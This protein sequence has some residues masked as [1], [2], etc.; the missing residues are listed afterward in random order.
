MLELLNCTEDIERLEKDQLR[1]C[2]QLEEFE[3]SFQ[4][5][6]QDLQAH[7]TGY[8]RSLRVDMGGLKRNVE[9]NSLSLSKYTSL[10]YV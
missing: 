6:T 10:S 8:Y 1:L 2:R 7:S 4:G 5:A 3:S 9:D